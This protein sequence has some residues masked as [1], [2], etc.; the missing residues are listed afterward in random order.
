[1]NRPV[2]L[3]HRLYNILFVP[4]VMLVLAS[5]VKCSQTPDPDD[6]QELA[7]THQT[8]ALAQS[9]Q[10]DPPSKNESRRVSRSF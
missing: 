1:M 2:R 5:V 10:A 7:L 3:V 9:I 6:T 4:L 8:T